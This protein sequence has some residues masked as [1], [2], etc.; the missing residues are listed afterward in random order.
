M[1][2][3]LISACLLG[4]KCR[5]DGKSK[6]IDSAIIKK[7]QDKYFLIPV[8]PEVMGGLSTPRKPCEICGK[9]VLTEDGAD[10]TCEYL[11][12]A[13]AVLSLAKEN[14]VKFCILKNKSP[15]CGNSLIYDGS[16]SGKLINSMG[17]T[18]ELLKSN[19]YTIY[20]ENQFDLF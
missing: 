10:F 1:E 4:E 14:K 8:C 20:N 19:G 7:L 16:F 13:K 2:K 12:G 3:I 5:Y 9:K 18:A 11:N 15:S 6:P 17:I